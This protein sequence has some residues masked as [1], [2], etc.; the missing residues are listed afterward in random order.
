MLKSST[1]LNTYM[2]KVDSYSIQSLN[3]YLI[4]NGKIW[5]TPNFS[6]YFR[7]DPCLEQTI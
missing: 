2:L 6:P 4:P 1:Y 7:L 3:K 5:E